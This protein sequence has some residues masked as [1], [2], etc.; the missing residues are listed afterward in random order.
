MEIQEI[1]KI[2]SKTNDGFASRITVKKLIENKTVIFIE[3]VFLSNYPPINIRYIK[4]GNIYYCVR[5][6]G[7]KE[8]TFK[9]IIEAMN[10]AKAI[11][12]ASNA[13]LDQKDRGGNPYILHPLWVMHKIRHLG[14]DYMIVAVLH[15]VPEDT[16]VTIKDLMLFGFSQTVID[17]LILLTHDKSIPYMDYVKILAINEIARAVKLRDLE[18]N[19]KIT[20]L[21]G[22][23]D[24][25]FERLK[26]YQIAYD[27]LKNYQL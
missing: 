8:E 23:R 12:I 21:K 17:A 1:L 6:I 10:L 19:S 3:Q 7:F 13:H 4:K 16:S 11:Q 22:L 26:K 18:H 20:R 9:Q 5:T 2:K 24:K 25:D 27:Y 14:E 15:D